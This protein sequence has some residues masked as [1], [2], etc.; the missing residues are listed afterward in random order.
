[1]FT[2]SSF[3][4]GH[5]AMS[6]DSEKKF[7]WR[8]STACRVNNRKSLS[9]FFLIQKQM[10]ITQALATAKNN[11]LHF[12]FCFRVMLDLKE[13]SDGKKNFSKWTLVRKSDNASGGNYSAFVKP[14]DTDLSVN[15]HC[16]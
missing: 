8:R 11:I 4:A 15:K 13:S 10:D 9:G 14:L 16:V 5:E 7:R 6:C 1:M 2:G 12:V 3:Y